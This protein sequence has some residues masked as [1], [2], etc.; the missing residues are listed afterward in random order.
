MQRPVLS[1]RLVERV[2]PDLHLSSSLAIADTSLPEKATKTQSHHRT[3]T[4]RSKTTDTLSPNTTTSGLNSFTPFELV[5]ASSTSTTFSTLSTRSP[6]IKPQ[7]PATYFGTRIYSQPSSPAAAFQSSATF[8]PPIISVALVCSGIAL[9]ALVICVSVYRCSSA[10]ETEKY[11]YNAKESPIFGGRGMNSEKYTVM[12]SLDSWES[13]QASL[14]HGMGRM[15][16]AATP[17][18]AQN[19]SP[20]PGSAPETNVSASGRNAV[21]QRKRLIAFSISL[22]QATKAGHL[23]GYV[24]SWGARTA[25]AGATNTQRHGSY[26]SL[27]D[28][29]RGASGE[30]TPPTKSAYNTIP[31]VTATA[32][33]HSR[34]YYNSRI[35]VMP[36]SAGPPFSHWHHLHSGKHA[37]S[38]SAPMSPTLKRQN[39]PVTSGDILSPALQS[40]INFAVKST[41]S[42]SSATAKPLHSI[43]KQSGSQPS[44][45]DTKTSGRFMMQSENQSAMPETQSRKVPRSV[46]RPQRPTYRVRPLNAPSISQPDYVTHHPQLPATASQSGSSSSLANDSSGTEGGQPLPRV[47]DFPLPPDA[48]TLIA[49]SSSMKLTSADFRD[50]RRFSVASTAA[51][52]SGMLS[53]SP[54]GVL[55]NVGDLMMSGFADSEVSGEET[56]DCEDSL[57][58]TS[59]AKRVVVPVLKDAGP[60]LGTT[61]PRSDDL[62]VSL[63]YDRIRHLLTMVCRRANPLGTPYPMRLRRSHH[64]FLPSW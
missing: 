37:L 12:G 43:L 23:N 52:R 3:R 17:L 29:T 21:T 5:T 57:V 15:P 7:P 50:K 64:P 31:N 63:N 24:G 41:I 34:T 59:T 47:L 44:L 39:V 62:N 26:G 13:L 40:T 22:A 53:G 14:A 38:A 4:A 9:V 60:S 25:G 51:R 54:S 19:L 8:N 30:D 18:T 49:S 11:H 10:R 28:S 55:A 42:S 1:W 46:Q 61:P 20:S 32:N 35:P 2:E 27:N 16:P 36:S 33:S 6:L 56:T 58:V 45:T 48:G